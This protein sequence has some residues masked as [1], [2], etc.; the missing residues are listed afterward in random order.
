MVLYYHAPSTPREFLSGAIA[1][2]ITIYGGHAKMSLV[3]TCSLLL[4]RMLE[5][6]ER[7]ECLCSPSSSLCKKR[8]M[9]PAH[10]SSSPPWLALSFGGARSCAIACAF[11]EELKFQSRSVLGF[12]GGSR[13]C[14]KS[15]RE[16]AISIRDSHFR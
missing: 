7:E 15:E 12:Y 13:R 9:A 4:I 6:S 5:Y 10:L 11:I 8:K 14:D 16:S 2:D 1:C 3:V